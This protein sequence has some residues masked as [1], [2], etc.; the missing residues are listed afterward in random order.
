MASSYLSIPTSV[1]DRAWKEAPEGTSYP[2]SDYPSS[3]R[4]TKKG[5][6]L[7]VTR[8]PVSGMQR[9]GIVAFP[10][11]DDFPRFSKGQKALMFGGPSQFNPGAIGTFEVE[12]KR[13]GAPLK[14]VFAQSHFRSRSLQSPGLPP[15]VTEEEARAYKDSYGEELPSAVWQLWEQKS[16]SSR[17]KLKRL[18]RQLE[19]YTK[20]LRIADNAVPRSLASKYDGWWYHAMSE[21]VDY[22][23][24]RGVDI[25]IPRAALRRTWVPWA[26][27]GG[28][29]KRLPETLDRV[30]KERGIERR[31]GATRTVI[32]T[33]RQQP[34]T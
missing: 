14:L 29:L 3:Y 8:M 15:G 31:A 33:S 20:Y 17:F 5:K 11:P 13:E 10:R 23:V 12:Q 27:R 25:H 32:K 26:T 7:L 19:D 2:E 28:R 1:V 18:K 6:T 24:E 21:L 4:V 22:A 34:R 9:F 16:L 30:C